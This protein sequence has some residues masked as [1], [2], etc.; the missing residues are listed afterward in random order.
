MFSSNYI[1]NIIKAFNDND[2][3]IIKVIKE[4]VAA[5][6]YYSIYNNIKNI[7]VFDMGCG[8]TDISIA[9][10]DDGFIDIIDSYGYNNLGSNNIN[11]NLINY[12]NTTDYNAEIKKKK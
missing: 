6:T 4:P 12:F 1:S 11:N 7:T 8:T 3:K 5:I 10:I 2:I 9:E